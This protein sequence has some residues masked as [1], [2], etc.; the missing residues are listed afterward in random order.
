M[1]RHLKSQAVP[2][3]AALA[4]YYNSTLP[5][6]AAPLP[7]IPPWLKA[8]A[9]DN[10]PLT[11]LRQSNRQ[12]EQEAVVTAVDDSLAVYVDAAIDSCVLHTSLVCPTLPETQHTC[13]YVT[14]APFPSVLAELAAIRDGLTLMIPK[15]DCLSLNRLLVYTDSTQAVRELRK[16]S[17]SLDI[18]SDVHRLIY[19]CACP[20]RVLWTRRSTLAQMAA[21]AACH[22]AEVQHP[23]PLLR[24][25]DDEDLVQLMEL[26]SASGAPSDCQVATLER[27]LQWPEG[28]Q[29]FYS[30]FSACWAYVFPALDLLRL[31]FR[32]H[33]VSSRMHRS[34][35]AKLCDR[36]LSLLVPTS[37][38]TSVNQMLVLRCLSNMFLTPSGEALVLQER[39]KIMTILHQHATLEGSKNTQI[40]M[41]TL[42]LNFAVA[43]QNE[44]AQCNPNAVEQ[45]SEILTTMVALT[46]VMRESEAQFLL[47]IAAGTLCHVPATGT[48]EI[49]ELAVALELPRIAENWAGT[50]GCPV[51]V[52]LY[53]ENE[54]SVMPVDGQ[55]FSQTS[56]VR[57]DA[58]NT[59][60]MLTKMREFNNQVPAADR[61]DDE[62]LVQL[63][64]LASASGAPSD[65]QVA[66]IERVLQW[67]EAYV[68]PALDLLRLAFRNHLVSSRMHRSSGAKLC[69]RLL[70]LLVPTSLNTSVN[71]MLVLRCLSN[72]MLVLRCLSNM[73]LTPSGEALVLQERRKIM[74]ILHQH[75]TLE[76]S[77]NTQ[78]AMATLLLNFAVAHQNEGA[79]CNPNAVEQMSEIL[80]TMV[81]LTAVMRESE[82]Q[83]LLLIAADAENEPSVMPVDG[84]F[85]SQTSFVRFD[86]A[87]TQGMLTKMREFNNQV[88]AA[89]RVDDE[90]L[91]Q[92]ME[93]ASA[94]GAPSDCQVATIER[95][96]Q[97]PE[98]YVFPAL[99]LLR[100]AFRNH[101]VSSRMHRS[102]GAKLC[103][104]LL[105]LLVPTSLNTSVNQMLVLRCLSNMFLTPSGEALVLQERRKIMTILHQHATLEGSKNTQ[106]AMATLLLNFAVAHQNE[107]AQCN[108]NAVE[109]MSEILTTM[110]ALTAVMRESEAQFLLL[111]AAGT[112]CHVPATGTTEIR[113]LAVA[114]ELPRIAENW[115][116]TDGCPNPNFIP[117]I[118]EK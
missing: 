3:A 113:E 95:V 97:W 1:A 69:D 46:A 37:L 118:E 55:F 25:V 23:L 34:S 31:A 6:P 14:E 112:L 77:K 35:G 67:P 65:C 115:A 87:N 85:F 103:D 90:D 15:V 16:V 84:Q 117:T 68:F 79:Q 20:V 64:E 44:G 18:A 36:L 114:L 56:F 19:S 106:I 47:L 66:T 105:S 27:V 91:V 108:P 92:L 57:F 100:L 48:T 10:R 8:Q 17:S 53:A 13:S 24:F 22:P 41:A 111:I 58:A 51:K 33:L 40:A 73:F 12:V 104:R 21:D 101:L 78:I 116:G 11:R 9:S 93:L 94:S 42:L 52:K 80:T 88:P 43:H 110:V 96:L 83:F 30:D 61:V 39:R 102:S 72:Q 32:N 54:P 59:Q 50:D 62:D 60:G 71:Q 98:A 75:A 2:A 4:H 28:V 76:G 7:E 107:G 86:A 26:A 82:A 74:T 89:D 29:G 81:A 45:M 99:D 63:M 109:Q 70:S 38:N 5:H 49:R